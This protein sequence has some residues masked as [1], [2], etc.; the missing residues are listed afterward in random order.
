MSATELPYEQLKQAYLA[1]QGLNNSATAGWYRWDSGE[2]GWSKGLG[3]KDACDEETAPFMSV[4]CLYTGY[5]QWL[6]F[7][8]KYNDLAEGNGTAWEC[9]N[10]ANAWAKAYLEKNVILNV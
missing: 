1:E 9:L 4:K 3:P 2:T 6:V 7:D 8:E 10:A 5:W